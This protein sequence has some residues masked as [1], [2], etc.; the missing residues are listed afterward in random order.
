MVVLS[1]KRLKS[2]A[3]DACYCIGLGFETDCGEVDTGQEMLYTIIA[4]DKYYYL[5][6]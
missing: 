4:F 1:F 6:Q 2:R 5:K 3:Y